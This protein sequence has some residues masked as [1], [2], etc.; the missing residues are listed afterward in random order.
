[1]RAQLIELILSVGYFCSS[2]YIIHCKHLHFTVQVLCVFSSAR[3]L[4]ECLVCLLLKCQHKLEQGTASEFKGCTEE[5]GLH[6]VHQLPRFEER[7]DQFFVGDFII[8]GWQLSIHLANNT[9]QAPSSV[10]AFL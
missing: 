8:V 7:I 1:M 5:A 3:S 4:S 9:T 2:F 10:R 6:F